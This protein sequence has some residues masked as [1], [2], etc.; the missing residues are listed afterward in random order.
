MSKIED[1][2][3]SKIKVK[4]REEEFV[5]ENGFTIEET[6]AINLA[7]GQQNQKLKAE[8]LRELLKV[9]IKR[10]YPNATE[11]Q[12]SQVDAKYSTDIL[13]VFYQLDKTEDNEK[14][15][16]RAALEKQTKDLEEKK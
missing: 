1:L 12:V 10:L 14:D 6:P 5:L 15:K 2:I 11:K 7:F 16:I 9:I 8:G 4:F 13:E 3:S